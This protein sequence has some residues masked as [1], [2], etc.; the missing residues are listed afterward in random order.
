MADNNDHQ[1]QLFDESSRGTV[2]ALTAVFFVLG[3]ALMLG[4]L[5]VSSYAFNPPAGEGW[6]AG[7]FAGGILLST[8][9]F[10]LPFAV[11]PAIRK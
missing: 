6:Q 10:V 5:I 11:L 2:G 4:G 8:L 9:G 1:K 7:M 3:F